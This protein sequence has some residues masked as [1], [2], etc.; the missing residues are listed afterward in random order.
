[1]KTTVD[2]PSTLLREAKAVAAR[3]GR[4]LRDFVAEAMHEKLQT[5]PGE[6]PWMKHFGSLSK[7]RKESRRI[8]K[9]VEREF[10]KIDRRQWR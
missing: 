3:Q 9:V 8:E 5:T 6:K 4:T 2:L 1:M 10:E 7:L